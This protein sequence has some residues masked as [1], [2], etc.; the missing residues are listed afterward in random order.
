MITKRIVT[1]AHVC[2]RT[3]AVA[4]PDKSQAYFSKVPES[5]VPTGKTVS[6]ASP[7]AVTNAIASKAPTAVYYYQE[8]CGKCTLVR[9]PATAVVVVVVAAAAAA[10]AAAGG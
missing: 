4:D 9:K 8:S 2:A 10:A 5:A 6:A 1:G 3:L 7:S